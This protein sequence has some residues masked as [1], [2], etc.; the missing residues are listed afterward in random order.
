MNL[1]QA[2]PIGNLGLLSQV[3]IQSDIGQTVKV[4]QAR[5]QNL[6][7]TLIIQFQAEFND[8]ESRVENL[9]ISR[10]MPQRLPTIK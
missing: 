10:G 2:S 5:C 8:L 6:D 3:P 7:D 9:D 4:L 1:V